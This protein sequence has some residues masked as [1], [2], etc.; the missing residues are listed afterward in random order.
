MW[1]FFLGFFFFSLRT[2]TFGTGQ[3]AL[4]SLIH[5]PADQS[6]HACVDSLDDSDQRWFSSDT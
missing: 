1:F 4:R 5:G 2:L 6:V 3:N